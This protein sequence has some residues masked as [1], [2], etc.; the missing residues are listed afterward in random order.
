MP[1]GYNTLATLLNL[2][3]PETECQYCLSAYNV[4]K[5][6]WE[7]VSKPFPAGF[8]PATLV[9]PRLELLVTLGFI[10][11]Q[12][13]VDKQTVEDAV[14]AWRAP[15][16][17]RVQR[18]K[19]FHARHG[20]SAMKEPGT[21]ML[22]QKRAFAQPRVEAPIYS[23]PAD[24]LPEPHRD[25]RRAIRALAPAVTSKEVIIRFPDRKGKNKALP[26]DQIEDSAMIV[27]MSGVHQPL[28]DVDAEGELEDFPDSPK[29][30]GGLEN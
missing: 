25:K 18:T 19:Q 26:E 9:D 6:G 14:R 8:L 11:D 20:S 15:S 29:E 2:A 17:Q 1:I 24:V 5:K 27:D 21:R 28:D 4:Q 7:K 3:D 16:G 23:N 13:N 12:G 22:P 10:T 30:T